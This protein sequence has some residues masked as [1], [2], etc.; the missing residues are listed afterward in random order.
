MNSF[1]TNNCYC[2]CKVIHFLKMNF[3]AQD[4]KFL[5]LVTDIRLCFQFSY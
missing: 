3:M 2:F 4:N 1:L 5:S